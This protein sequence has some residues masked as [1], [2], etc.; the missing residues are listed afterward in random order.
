MKKRISVIILCVALLAPILSFAEEYAK[1]AV[2]DDFVVTFDSVK[3]SGDTF[4]LRLSAYFDHEA[5]K[6]YRFAGW[7]TL[8]Y[9][10]EEPR[11]MTTEELQKMYGGPML[12]QKIIFMAFKTLSGEDFAPEGSFDTL[13]M[14]TFSTP[15]L[16]KDGR[17]RSEV[18]YRATRFTTKE[19]AVLVG[20]TVYD[21]HGEAP[22]TGEVEQTV[23]I[24]LL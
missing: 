4:V 15:E 12:T 3:Q 19:E 22:F 7:P 2:F 6:Y 17:W 13:E 5:V 8:T 24:E 20:F 18:E 23:Y 9:G 16:Q 14:G 10:V 11:D 1:E 21:P